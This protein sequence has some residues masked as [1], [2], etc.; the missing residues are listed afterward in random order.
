DDGI[1]RA[2]DVEFEPAPGA[3]LTWTWRPRRQQG[4]KRG[5][6]DF[7]RFLRPG[8]GV[9][10]SF[11]RFGIIEREEVEQ[12]GGEVTVVT[13]DSG[14]DVAAGGVLTLFDNAVV[15]TIGT[16]LTSRVEPMTAE[17]T[18]SL[19]GEDEVDAEQGSNWYVGVGFS[20][21]GLADKLSR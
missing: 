19:G 15:L 10:V 2:R 1:E 5:F 21:V 7:F 4:W 18:D 20:F 11:P 13:E 14:L 6:A 3:S 12:A 17:Q 9:N 8:F 16:A